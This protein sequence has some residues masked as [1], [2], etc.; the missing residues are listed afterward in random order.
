MSLPTT[1]WL[2]WQKEQRKASSDPA[3]FKQL[4]PVQP[5]AFYSRRRNRGPL[6][7]TSSSLLSPETAILAIPRALTRAGWGTVWS[8]SYFYAG[9]PIYAVL[10]G[11]CRFSGM[12]E[13]IVQGFLGLDMAG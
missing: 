4:S 11:L 12:F 8:G 1:S 9:N 3:R 6:S 7:S 10:R 5:L 2:L 13:Q